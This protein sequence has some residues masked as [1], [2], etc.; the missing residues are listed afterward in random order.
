MTDPFRQQGAFSWFEL[1][2]AEVKA[3]EEFYSRLFGWTTE[4][5]LAAGDGY[6]LVKVGGQQIGGIAGAG[7]K[8]AQRPAAWGIYVTVTD[9]DVTARK[10]VELGGRVLVEPQDIPKVGR[11]CVI[12]DPQGGV[13][14][15]ITYLSG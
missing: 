5:W 13:I 10:V 4:P 7:P 15:A 1:T 6:R 11:F 9:V 14:R 8:E 2:T 3:A 12:E